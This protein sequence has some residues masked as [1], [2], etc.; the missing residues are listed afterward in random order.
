MLW[1]ILRV[2][3][4]FSAFLSGW[5][6]S[7]GF[8]SKGSKAF[9]LGAFI[10]AIWH[11]VLV[12]L[13]LPLLKL[14]L[15]LYLYYSLLIP[16]QICCHDCSVTSHTL[17]ALPNTLALCRRELKWDA[18]RLNA[19]VIISMLGQRHRL[20]CLYLTTLSDS[21]ELGLFSGSKVRNMSWIMPTYVV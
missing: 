6:C 20:T 16:S 5:S 12:Y 10:I 7:C 18:L 13:F 11:L 21:N 8:W 1:H 3:P 9:H 17:R 4:F 14:D 19:G 2:L 15:G